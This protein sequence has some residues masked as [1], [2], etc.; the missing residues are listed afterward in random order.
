[1]PR[2]RCRVQAGG[3]AGESEMKKRKPAPVKI[4]AWDTTIPPE[5]R[6]Y[7]KRLGLVPDKHGLPIATDAT[8]QLLQIERL[9]QSSFIRNTYVG[10]LPSA[11]RYM[12]ADAG[13]MGVTR[14]AWRE[15]ITDTH[16]RQYGRKSPVAVKYRQ[17]CV[18][19]VSAC[20]ELLIG[21]RRDRPDQM[22]IRL[23]HKDRNRGDPDPEGFD[24]VIRIA[25]EILLEPHGGDYRSPPTLSFQQL[26][27]GLYGDFFDLNRPVLEI[28]REGDKVVGCRPG[29]AGVVIPAWD[30]VRRWTGKNGLMADGR[31]LQNITDPEKL[32]ALA[33][34]IWKRDR[35][36]VDLP[37][38]E[39][40]VYRDGQVDGA[41]EPGVLIVLPMQT[42]TDINWA[43]HPPSYLQLGMEFAAM[44]WTIWDYHGRK[45]TDAAWA[46]MLIAVIGEGYDD[47]G[48][49]EFLQNLRTTK[50]YQRA[51][52]PH[53]VHVADGGDIK[54]VDLKPPLADAEFGKLDERVDA[55]F[56]AIVRRHPE[57][58]NGSVPSAS[59]PRLSGPSEEMRIRF[60]R[61]EG[62]VRDVKH[63]AAVISRFVRVAVHP[64]MR[65]Y[66]VLPGPDRQSVVEL[67]SKEMQF[68]PVNQVL[69]EQ[70]GEAPHGFYLPP[71]ELAKAG[72]A[73]RKKWWE[74]PYNYPIR[75]DM[76]ALVQFCM[77]L[78]KGAQDGP[79]QVGPD[80]KPVP[81]GPVTLDHVP[82]LG[83]QADEQ[84]QSEGQADKAVA[85][86]A[87]ADKADPMARIRALVA[88]AKEKRNVAQQ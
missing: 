60:A 86:K 16:L 77:G 11:P 59:G 69:V 68:R 43:G 56:G 65:A 25:E 53:V 9:R 24:K 36:S 87:V 28:L 10:R 37:R 4:D 52:L 45:F 62:T 23:G 13:G 35:V 7:F 1:M 34:E 46:S 85:D 55:G 50:G 84:E 2:L 66:P 38:A 64:D 26:I 31:N 81:A 75:Q 51:G 71:E 21:N 74:N 49:N 72:D 47:E 83:K 22:G 17:G 80:G 82:G 61:E 20:C 29:D 63:M 15:P 6:A 39:W 41:V 78:Q 44:S 67:W 73:D 57:I 40:V 18:S 14:N 33:N 3:Q 5:N 88:K 70:A 8:P 42:S 58:I 19:Q 27:E 79:P 48:F 32:E 54:T 30:L 12:T 76:V